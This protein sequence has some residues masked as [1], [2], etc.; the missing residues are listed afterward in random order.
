MQDNLV[1]QI[2]DEQ[3]EEGF[4]IDNDGAAEWALQKIAEETADAQRYINVCDTMI[5]EYQKKR[6]KAQEQLANKTGYLKGKLQEYFATVPHKASKTQESY[7]LPSGTLKLKYGRLKFIQDET[8]FVNWLKNNGYADKVK[9]VESADW[10]EFKKLCE[11][12][13]SV[14]M[15]ADGEIVEGVTVQEEPNAFEVEI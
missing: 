1:L 3:F 10:V 14:V 2:I 4:K 5:I 6:Q 8:V 11:I 12:G 15:T 13:S 9:T 7:K